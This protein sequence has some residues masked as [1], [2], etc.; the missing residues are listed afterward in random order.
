[1]IRIEGYSGKIT[2]FSF[3]YLSCKKKNA[4]KIKPQPIILALV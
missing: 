2:V 3:L 1:M 4:L